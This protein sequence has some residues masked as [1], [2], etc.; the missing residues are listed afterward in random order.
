M[1]A[2]CEMLQLLDFIELKVSISL[3]SRSQLYIL[4]TRARERQELRLTQCG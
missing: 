3:T 1:D 4:S 2:F